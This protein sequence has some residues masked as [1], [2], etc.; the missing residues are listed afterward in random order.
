[1]NQPRKPKKV[2]APEGCKPHIVSGKE[3]DI[4]DIDPFVSAEH[5]HAFYIP[6]NETVPVF[7]LEKGCG[8]LNGQDWIVTEWEDENN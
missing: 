4:L 5:G 8:H 2:K 7:C 6:T 3:Y 1:M